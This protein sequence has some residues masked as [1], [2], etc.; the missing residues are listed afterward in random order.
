MISLFIDT[1]SAAPDSLLNIQQPL[2]NSQLFDVVKKLG[3]AILIGALVGLEREFS[4]KEDEKIFAGIRTFPLISVCGFTAALLSTLTDFW[5]YI[6]VFIAF[7]LVLSVSQIYRAREGNVGGT[8]EIATIIVFILGSLVF[9]NY[10]IL[11]AGIAVIVTLFLSLKFQLH[12]FV[13]K[14]NEKDIYATIKLAILSVIILPLLPDKTYGPL[15]V[16]NPFMIWLMVIFISGISFIGY[17]LMKIIGKEEGVKI[18][19][20]LGGMVSSTAVAFSFSKRSK[21]HPDLSIYLA[22]G[23]ILA[24]SVMFPRVLFVLMILNQQLISYLWIPLSA[25]TLISFGTAWLIS[26]RIDKTETEG[27]EINNPFEL[28]SALL[29]GLIFGLVI[30]AAKAAET[31]LGSAGVYAASGLAGLSSVDAIVVSLA[32]L[33][34]NGI[35]EKVASAAVLIAL[36]SNSIVKGIIAISL[37]SKELKKYTTIG[38]GI[39]TSLLSAYLVFYL[40]TLK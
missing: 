10:T 1:L 20:L 5:I 4:K 21:K 2:T 28:K 24:S 9:W 38:L 22:V 35:N 14:I 39:V 40:A 32:N 3:I 16:L 13:G 18:T 30:F 27:I 26:K 29:F 6:A 7:S 15:E 33:S 36:I 25:F 34:S 23:I 31:Y 11:A 12:K 8:S 19:G 17:V 37:G